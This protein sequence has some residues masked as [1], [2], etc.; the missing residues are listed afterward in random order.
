MNTDR[1]STI[2]GTITGA[3]IWTQID[4]ARLFAKDP[5]EITKLTLGVLVI[6]QGWLQNKSFKTIPVK[7]KVK[8]ITLVSTP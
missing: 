6:V 5:V 8:K 7:R 1:L 3:T 2:L 4:W